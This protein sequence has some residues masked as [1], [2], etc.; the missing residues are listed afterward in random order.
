VQDH[1]AGKDTSSIIQSEGGKDLFAS[2]DSVPGPYQVLS[3]SQR[4]HATESQRAQGP[5]Y[6][7]GRRSEA[8]RDPQVTPVLG[9]E[10]PPRRPEQRASDVSNANH[11]GMRLP[12]PA[13]QSEPSESSGVQS[14]S[15]SGIGMDSS[16]MKENG[17]AG[18]GMDR[19]RRGMGS[20]SSRSGT[21]EPEGRRSSDMTASGTGSVLPSSGGSSG[22]SGASIPISGRRGAA[23]GVSDGGVRLPFSIQVQVSAGANETRRNGATERD[24]GTDGEEEEG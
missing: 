8:P 4:A 2:S 1:H 21:A 14:G 5:H 3:E 11:A 24:V 19:R 7:S 13:S 9:S 16:A 15:R 12:P 23:M 18:V 17:T 6:R 10:T 20:S 22:P